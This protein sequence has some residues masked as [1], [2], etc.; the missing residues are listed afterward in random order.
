[1][2]NV[3]THF[4]FKKKTR[5]YYLYSHFIDEEL[6]KLSSSFL[7]MELLADGEFEPSLF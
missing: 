6:E 5:K 1:M 4:I 2:L 3:I 7:A